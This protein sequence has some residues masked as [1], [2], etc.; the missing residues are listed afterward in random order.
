MMRFGLRVGFGFS[1]IA[2]SLKVLQ[3]TPPTTKKQI[4]AKYFE[5]AKQLHPDVNEQEKS[6]SSK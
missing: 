5:L 2:R 1:K 6:S 3:L 4:K